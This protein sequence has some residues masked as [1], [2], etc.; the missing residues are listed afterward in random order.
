MGLGDGGAHVAF[1]LDA[2]YPTWLLTHWGKRKQRWSVQEL[3]RRLTSD[4]AHAAGLRTAASSR[5]GRR[6][7][8]T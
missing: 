2:G 5:R 1:I 3:V 8:S 7:T 4:T 6:P